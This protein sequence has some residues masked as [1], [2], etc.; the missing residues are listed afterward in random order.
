[1][2]SETSESRLDTVLK[3]IAGARDSVDE[4]FALVQ[5]AIEHVPDISQ[6]KET[7]SEEVR[8]IVQERLKITVQREIVE[9]IRDEVKSAVEQQVS[10]VVRR[11]VKK[12]VQQEVKSIVKQEVQS[13]VQREVMNIVTEKVTAIVQ[14]QAIKEV[15]QFIDDTEVGKKPAGDANK[16]DSWDVERLDWSAEEEDRMLKDGIVTASKIV[17]MKSEAR[18]NVEVIEMVVIVADMP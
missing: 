17:R 4:R 8:N 15:L 6:V 1:M 12:V 18:A 11:E 2:S 10:G 16:N 13:I 3:A 7:V 9:A 14:Q 5:E